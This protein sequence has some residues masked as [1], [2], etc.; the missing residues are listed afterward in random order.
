MTWKEVLKGSADP[1]FL[2]ITVPGVVGTTRHV[3]MKIPR[4]KRLSMSKL[5]TLIKPLAMI[6]VKNITDLPELMRT[7][8]IILSQV[9]EIG[10]HPGLLSIGA[11][12]ESGMIEV[13]TINGRMLFNSFAVLWLATSDENIP[14]G[15]K[16]NSTVI[17]IPEEEDV[18]EE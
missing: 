18:F 4:G 15:F 8:M 5:R 10:K 3:V 6:E 11:A 17:T 16:K 9:E 2:S 14:E 1:D 7:D 13:D 12:M